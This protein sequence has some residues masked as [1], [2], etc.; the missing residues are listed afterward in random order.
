MGFPVIRGSSSSGGREALH[1]FERYIKRGIPACVIAD[2]PRGPARKAKIG[3][4]AAARETGAPILTMGVS[5]VPCLRA[6]NWDRTVIP[7]PFARIVLSFGEPIW[8]P[9]DASRED[10]ERIRE[11]VDR[12][13]EE[14]E[15]T[16]RRVSGASGTT[17]GR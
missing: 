5:V 14:L 7:H 13:M 1:E 16:S 6:K 12:R 11:D 15:A 17:S 4:V 8:V 9:K 3:C 10:C 2:G